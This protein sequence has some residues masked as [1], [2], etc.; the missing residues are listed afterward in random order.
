MKKCLFIIFLTLCSFFVFKNEVYAANAM[1]G[2][3]SYKLDNDTILVQII[4]DDYYNMPGGI[5][6]YKNTMENQ[7]YFD[8]TYLLYNGTATFT[9]D[10]KLYCP[11]ELYLV[12]NYSTS[13]TGGLDGYLYSGVPNGY[14][15]SSYRKLTFKEEW[16]EGFSSLGYFSCVYNNCVDLNNKNAG[17][18]EILMDGNGSKNFNLYGTIKDGGSGQLKK[19]VSEKLWDL[20]EVF[21]EGKCPKYAVYG[22]GTKD[23]VWTAN[24][25]NELIVKSKIRSKSSGYICELNEND[26]NVE[27]ISGEINN[28]VGDPN[29]NNNNNNSNQ[30]LETGNPMDCDTLKSTD[31]Y[32]IIKQIFGWIQILAP[33]GLVVLG[34]IDFITAVAASDNDAMKKAQSKFVKRCI[35]VAVIILFPFV[36]SVLVSLLDGALGNTCGL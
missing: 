7:I 18:Y 33:I 22:D 21:Y 8:S 5:K 27:N 16:R 32:K 9:K 10:Q 36:F 29:A 17:T 34:V 1:Q 6:F 35:V 20:N 28:Q 15:S 19:N 13:S 23:K 25:K 30:Q 4:A 11:T 31:T 26:S 14:D 24:D 3:C 12:G 2:I